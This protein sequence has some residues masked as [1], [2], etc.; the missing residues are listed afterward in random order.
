[1]LFKFESHQYCGLK[2]YEQGREMNK[3]TED[4]IYIFSWLKISKISRLK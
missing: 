4:D 2:K 1:M 3:M